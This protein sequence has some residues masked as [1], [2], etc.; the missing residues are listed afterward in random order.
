MGINK[1]DNVRNSNIELLRIVSMIMI[2]GLHYFNGEMGGGAPICAKKQRQLLVD[3][4]I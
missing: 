4:N 2:I 3:A 1:R